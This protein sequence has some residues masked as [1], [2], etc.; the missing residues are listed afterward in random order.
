LL[1]WVFVIV[2]MLFSK[3]E[4]DNENFFEVLREDKVTSFDVSMNKASVVYLFNGLQ[5]FNE[6]LN[7][8]A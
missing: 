6:K 8:Y 7:S 4:V 1:D 5:H 3:A 2:Q